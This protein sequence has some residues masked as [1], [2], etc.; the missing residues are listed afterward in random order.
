MKQGAWGHQSRAGRR[1]RE[2]EERGA[3][4]G[5]L[6]EKKRGCR[7]AAGQEYCQGEAEGI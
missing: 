5:S 4:E 6:G 1:N 3:R 7:S 2:L